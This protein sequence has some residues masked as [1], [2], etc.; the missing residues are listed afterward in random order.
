MIKALRKSIIK[1]PELESKYVKN[2]TNKNLKSYKNK[3][4]S[5]ANC[6]KKKEKIL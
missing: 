2:K 4:V 6:I 5:V 1:R 3:E